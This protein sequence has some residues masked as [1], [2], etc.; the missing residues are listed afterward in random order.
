[1]PAQHML[2]DVGV[3]P[4]SQEPSVP[5]APFSE[6]KLPEPPWTMMDWLPPLSS[7]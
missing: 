5:M 6:L 7:A 2:P 4:P 3:V 1:M